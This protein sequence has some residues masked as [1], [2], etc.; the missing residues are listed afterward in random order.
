MKSH[1]GRMRENH[2]CRIREGAPLSPEKLPCLRMRRRRVPAEELSCGGG[3]AGGAG[4]VDGWSKEGLAA[5]V[6][7][8]EQGPSKSLS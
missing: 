6:L 4:E 2:R 3:R 7:S 1:R 8:P 5:A